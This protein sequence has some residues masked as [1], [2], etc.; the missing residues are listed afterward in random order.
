LLV[1]AISHSVTYVSKDTQTGGQE[2]VH[3][4]TN[5]EWADISKPIGY[6]SPTKP[7]ATQWERQ[8]DARVSEAVHVERGAACRGMHSVIQ[9]KLDEWKHSAPTLRRFS[10]NATEDV[11]DNAI[12]ALCLTVGLRMVRCG[13][14]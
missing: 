10:A 6:L 2:L 1:L 7:R 8:G 4:F 5:S 13:H 3:L 12:D 14:V 11:F 9:R